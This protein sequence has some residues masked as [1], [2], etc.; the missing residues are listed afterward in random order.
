MLTYGSTIYI[1]GWHG[2]ASLFMTTELWDSGVGSKGQEVHRSTPWY[3]NSML[4]RVSPLCADPQNIRLAEIAGPY[5]SFQRHLSANLTM[6]TPSCKEQGPGFLGIFLVFLVFFGFMRVDVA[7][8]ARVTRMRLMPKL[9][10]VL[11][12]YFFGFAVMGHADRA[13][14]RMLSRMTQSRPVP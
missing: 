9:Q 10:S 4:Q 3:E 1:D 8:T 14:E 11:F 2:Q 13:I 6:S 5:T 7:K 12:G